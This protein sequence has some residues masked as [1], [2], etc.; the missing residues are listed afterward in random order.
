MSP[1]KLIDSLCATFSDP[2][3]FQAKY[4]NDAKYLR[5]N[6]LHARVCGLLARVGL[7]LGF[8]VDFGRKFPIDPIAR[9]KQAEA[10]VSFVDP[11]NDKDKATSFSITKQAMRPSTR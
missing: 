4:L 3:L 1:T 9:Q 8:L 7:E 6:Q 5:S 11:D 2:R 10:D